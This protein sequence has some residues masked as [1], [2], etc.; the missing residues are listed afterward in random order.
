MSV[1]LRTVGPPEASIGAVQRTVR[2]V[3]PTQPA[4]NFVTMREVVH[5]TIA[6]DRLLLMLFAAFGAVAL[7]LAASGVY[8]VVS[9][10]VST[11]TREIGIR[12][13][14]GAVTNQIVGQVVR[15]TMTLAAAGLVIGLGISLFLARLVESLL[16]G[17]SAGDAATFAAVSVLLSMVA[18]VAAY[19]P[20]RRAAQVD[21]ATALRSHQ[22]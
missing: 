3:S 4:Y 17:V 19:V 5:E 13:A 6:E 8:G 2:R 9:Y 11:R 14:L 20:G 18:V 16:F 21:P 22:T 1:V 7:I 10:A 15:R 12:L